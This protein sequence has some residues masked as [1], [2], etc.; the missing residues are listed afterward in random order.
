M[1]DW[2]RRNS[3][4]KDA[5]LKTINDN[6]TDGLIKRAMKKEL[7]LDIDAMEIEAEKYYAEY[8]Y[9]G[10]KGYMPLLGFIPELDICCGYEFRAGNV[11]PQEGNYEFT[12][13]IIEKI[14]RA[15]KKIKQFRSDSAAY[16]AKL[17]N[18]LNAEGTKYTITA[19]QDEAVKE[20]IKTVDETNWKPVTNRDGLNTDR[21]YAQTLH[22]MNRSDH[23][24][25]LVIQ[26]WKNP[27]QDLYEKTQEYYYH[28]I[29]TNYLDQE[30]SAQEVIWHHNSR[31]NS[32]NY[33]KEL[34]CGFNLDYVPC[35]E[36]GA[37]AVWFGIGILAYNLFVMSKIYLFPESWLKK[38]IGT[39][40]WQFIQMAG[41]I[42]N[43]ARYMI[44]K[45]CGILMEIFKIYQIARE[46][47][48]ELQSIKESA[49]G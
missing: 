5:S 24:F 21:E 36:L 4:K 27:E 3:W 26:R 22:T 19:D 7:T 15:R 16:Q 42:V 44:V 49:C 14:K 33:N 18:Y 38:T 6:L 9:N 35:G 1:G 13:D 25:R 11:P 30:K 2:L 41:K 47:C 17:M 28:V 40:R 39:I 10:N 48:Y 37:N 29:A 34:K 12:K 32:E 8:T 45:V 31:S 20:M 46:K 23:A 43:R